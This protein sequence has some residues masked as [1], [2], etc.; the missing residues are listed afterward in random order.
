MS[1]SEHG[2]KPRNH[3]GNDPE[4]TCCL[5]VFEE[6]VCTRL[7]LLNVSQAFSSLAAKESISSSSSK[8]HEFVPSAK[9]PQDFHESNSLGNKHD[10]HESCARSGLCT[11]L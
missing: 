1:G 2:G 4:L 7:S 5:Y 11:Q 6:E 10:S 9:Q 3:V 8:E